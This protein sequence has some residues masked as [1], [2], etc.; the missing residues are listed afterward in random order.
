MMTRL[1]D[2]Y[3]ILS[4]NT[5]GL[6]LVCHLAFIA[7]LLHK[8]RIMRWERCCPDRLE[9]SIS[10]VTPALIGRGTVHME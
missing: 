5:E 8:A 6:Q 10:H 2:A 7:L 9:V 1:R 4:C 3:Q